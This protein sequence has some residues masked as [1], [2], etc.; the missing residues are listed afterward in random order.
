[1][2]LLLVVAL[3]GDHPIPAEA[4]ARM[5][6][7]FEAAAGR[8]AGDVDALSRRGDALFFLGRF[9]PAAADYHRMVEIDPQL[10]SQHWRRGIAY[11][12]A[13]EYVKAAKQFED[14]HSYDDVDRENG[15]WRFFSQAKAYGI[16]KAREGLLKY[17]KDDREPFP[18]VYEL[19]AGKTT[20]EKIL[21]QIKAATID[22]EQ[23][24]SR[25]FYAHLYIG[26]NHAVEGRSAEARESLRRAVANSWGPAA[27]YGPRYMWHV[28][29][30]HYELL[31]AASDWPR[32]RGPDGNGVS[33][34][35]PLPLKWSAT[36]HVAWK[37]AIPGEG[38]SSPIVSGDVVFVTSALDKGARR[39]VHCLDRTTGKIRWSRETKDENPERASAMTGHA[40][41][42][43][44]T[45]GSVVVAWFGNAGAVCYDL[46]GELLWRR[47]FG[48]FDSELGIASSPIL[49][50]G[51]VVLTCDHDGSKPRSFDSFLTALDLKTGKTI[52][53]TD[54]PGLERSWST[55]V[56][57][58]SD[59]LVNAQDE[60][61]AYDPATGKELWKVPGM[62]G[63]V[64]P[65]PVSG[66]GLIFA[67][68]GK[69]GPTIAFK[70]GGQV[71]WQEKRGGPYVCSPLLAGDQLYVH[72]ETGILVC[73]NAADGKKL[74]R[75]RLAPKFTASAVAGDG[76][77]YFTNESGTTFVVKA[78]PAFELLAEN[79]LGEEVLASP[80]IAR[81]ALFIRTEKHL[82]CIR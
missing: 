70:P 17:K 6:R 26:L 76:K 61:R 65:S 79:R 33:P 75:E 68:S 14:Y 22:D 32:W 58:G 30:I 23:R 35:S 27:G 46:S 47:P 2:I 80:A 69:D 54:R 40:A 55:P 31:R 77:V 25:Y 37:A 7:D 4:R 38:S 52:W 11:F 41:A 13:G 51:A 59:L 48:E 63:W 81:G 3:Q 36:D 18:S 72:D 67:T 15:I 45:D 28:G 49:H 16:E 43:P 60:L 50:Q 1:M 20:P 8:E 39:V 66:K 64:T 12:Y 71:V 5:T 53:K 42:T 74:Y 56:V 29:R 82:Y 19:F 10:G 44:V 21:D 62:T 24:E 34:E 9:A 57:V 73:R 78:G